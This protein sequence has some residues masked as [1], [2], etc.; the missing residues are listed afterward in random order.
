[1][2]RPGVQLGSGVPGG[3]EH[4][5]VLAG[6]GRLQPFGDH[7]VN[8]VAA[9]RN[10]ATPQ[11]RLS[12]STARGTWPSR[13]RPLACPA[14]VEDHIRRLK[15]SDL[16]RFPFADLDASR[17]WMAVVCFAA[18][19]VRFQLLCLTRPLALAESNA[20]RWRL[21]HSPARL[22]RQARRQVVRILDGWPTEGEILA[23]PTPSSSPSSRSGPGGA[24]WAG[25]GSPR[26]T[27]S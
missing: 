7:G 20:L 4:Q 27:A 14:H 1:M 19:L 16:E 23:P 9:L 2:A 3:G 6:F 8:E 17:A 13:R 25:P 5:G 11:M 10:R 26:P 21:W 18:D 22:V 15:D 12:R 24:R